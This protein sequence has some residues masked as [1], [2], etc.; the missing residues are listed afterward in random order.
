[1]GSLFSYGYNS[2]CVESIVLTAAQCIACVRQCQQLTNMFKPIYI[3]RLDE[4]TGDVFV[5]AGEDLQLLIPPDGDWRFI[6]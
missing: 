3:V 4:R 6:E 1:V 2:D 5:L